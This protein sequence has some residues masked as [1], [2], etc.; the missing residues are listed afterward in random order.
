VREIL[1]KELTVCGAFGLRIEGD[2]PGKRFIETMTAFRSHHMQMPY[3]DQAL[4]V[5]RSDFVHLAGFKDMAIMEDYDFVLRS[6]R[7]GRVAIAGAS[8]LT[9]GRR[10]R[11]LGVLRTTA[12]NQIVIAGYHLGVAPQTLADFYRRK[13]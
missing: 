13:Q 5:R 8:V 9:S 4:F 1:S 10:W 3:G 6:R 7:L 12:I 11:G 2:F